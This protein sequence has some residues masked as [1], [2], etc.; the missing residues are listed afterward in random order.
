MN[1]NLFFYSLFVLL[2]LV[3]VEQLSFVDTSVNLTK[4]HSQ[5][6]KRGLIFTN[7]GTLKLSI[8]PSMPVRLADP[9]AFRSLVCSYSLQGGHYK[10]PPEPT[11]PWDKWEDT[12]ARS[13]NQMRRRFENYGEYEQ[14]ESREFLYMV[15]EKY[16]SRNNVDG[17]QCLLRAICEN[18]Q[19][20]EHIGVFANVLDVV[21]TPGKENLDNSYRMALQAGRHGADCIKLFNSCPK[22]SSLLDQYIDEL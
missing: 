9:I 14:D 20:H 3:T 21:L 16:M 13:L 4:F 2:V 17:R 6:Q 19:V 10:I 8:G 1:Q 7:G 22:G 18:A 15:L 11:Y 5:R 12:F